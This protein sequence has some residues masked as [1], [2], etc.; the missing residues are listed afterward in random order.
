MLSANILGGISVHIKQ[1]VASDMP[2]KL[3][4]IGLLMEEPTVRKMLTQCRIWKIKFPLSLFCFLMR[5]KMKYTLY[6]LIQLFLA[7][8]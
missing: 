5:Y 3:R 4:Q 1:I 6:F 2:E 8:S 7:V